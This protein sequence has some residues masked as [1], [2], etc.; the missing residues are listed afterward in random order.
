MTSTGVYNVAT[1]NESLLQ[2]AHLSH[3]QDYYTTPLKS[4]FNDLY[5]LLHG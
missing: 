5:L 3:G 4:A 1:A 2:A